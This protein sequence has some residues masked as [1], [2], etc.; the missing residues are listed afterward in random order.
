MPLYFNESRY[1]DNEI[2]IKP[3]ELNLGVFV[4]AES[5]H[6]DYDLSALLFN[7]KSK[8]EEVDN[9]IF[10]NNQSNNNKS[11]YLEKESEEWEE[12]IYI[13][14]NQIDKSV[15]KIL[16]I[17]SIYD[18]KIPFNGYLKNLELSIKVGGIDSES[19][20]RVI[21]PDFNNYGNAN[22]YIPFYFERK[23]DKWF[24]QLKD[25][26]V[27]STGLVGLLNYYSTDGNETY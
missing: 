5:N 16:I 1:Y 12:I 21:I 13:K 27:F 2:E 22:V 14:L 6:C 19:L 9:L 7:D 26:Q 15:F 24:V 23:G 20:F 25:E 3:Q 11:I 4:R 17:I 10:Y 8:I 18:E